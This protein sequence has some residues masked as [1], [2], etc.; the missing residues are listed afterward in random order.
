MKVPANPYILFSRD[1]LTNVKQCQHCT[2][3]EWAEMGHVLNVHN[4]PNGTAF[5]KIR[6]T[7]WLDTVSFGTFF[8]QFV[9]FDEY[10]LSCGMDLNAFDWKDNLNIDSK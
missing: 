1:N 8:Y 4:V 6:L 2:S 9:E 7:T 3:T 5:L 10:A